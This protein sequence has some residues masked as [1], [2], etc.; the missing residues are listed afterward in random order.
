MELDMTSPENE[1]PSRAALAVE[2]AAGSVN[3]GLEVVLEAVRRLTSTGELKPSWRGWL[4]TATF[5]LAVL[6]GVLVTHH[7]RNGTATACALVWTVSATFLFGV[8]AL[9][10]RR[11]WG[12]RGYA[13][14]SRFDH[15]NIFLLIAGSFTPFGILALSGTTRVVVCSVVW[16]GCA[17]GATLRVVWVRAPRAL[18][19][20]L[21]VVMGWTAVMVLPRLWHDAGTTAVLLLGLGGVLYSI[22]GVIY[23]VRRPNPWPARFGFHEIFHAL[24]VLAFAVQAGAIALVVA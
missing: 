19:T 7:A 1:H 15:A 9:Y 8:S 23:G 20:G 2:R 13:V 18:T 11:T 22:G 6:T 12:P 10:H 3:D 21:Y 5:P 16:A 4:H 17:A 24:T 14:M